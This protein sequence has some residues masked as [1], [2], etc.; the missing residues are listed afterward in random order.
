MDSLP[1][2]YV[3]KAGKVE[4]IGIKSYGFDDYAKLIPKDSKSNY[5]EITVVQFL[6]ADRRARGKKVRVIGSELIIMNM[7]ANSISLRPC[8]A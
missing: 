8:T 7:Q 3:T 2:T 4:T 5:F 6:D 1:N